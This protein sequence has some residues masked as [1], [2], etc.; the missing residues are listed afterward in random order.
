MN[1]HPDGE[2][3]ACV[4]LELG[5]QLPDRRHYP[6]ASA[7]RPLGVI[8]MR[9]G[10]A[11]VDEQAVAEILG[12]MAVEALDDLGTCSLIGSHHLTPLFG[13]E[14]GGQRGRVYQITEDY[15][16]LAA[17]GFTC[18]SLSWWP[19]KRRRLI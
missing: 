14:P 6:E 3:D 5:I 17:L 4:L 19:S 2:L 7:H 9:P 1:S 13:V 10:I 8:L 16:E 12:D 18:I 11:E 15:S